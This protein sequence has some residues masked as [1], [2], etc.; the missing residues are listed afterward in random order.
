M[1]SIM[2]KI[3]HKPINLS[4]K[5]ALQI[6]RFALSSDQSFKESGSIR[7][8]FHYEFEYIEKMRKNAQFWYKLLFRK[9]DLKTIIIKKQDIIGREPG[10]TLYLMYHTERQ[11]EKDS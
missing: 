4:K 2:N 3:R 5:S 10:E 11:K 7:N 9:R 8:G 6:D 1:Y